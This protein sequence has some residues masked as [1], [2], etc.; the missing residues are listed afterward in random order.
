MN[1]YNILA[2]Y[3]AQKYIDR[4]SGNDL[5]DRIVGDDPKDQIMTGLLAE[6]R[7]EK[8]FSGFYKEN[9]DTKYESVPSIGLRF[10][11]DK[12]D[13]LEISIVP[14]GILFYS[15]LPNYEEVVEYF[16]R[17]ESSK[18]NKKYTNI[19]QLI[20]IYPDKQLTLPLVYK[21][22]RLENIFADGIKINIS[23]QDSESIHLEEDIF[24]ELSS[25]IQKIYKEIRVVNLE[26]FTYEELKHP[27]L[28]K[29]VCTCRE[30]LVYPSW[31]L[32]ILVSTKFLEDKCNIFVQMV[33]KSEKP[34]SRN[35]GFLPQIY[36]AGLDII[37]NAN[38]VFNEIKLDYFSD[39]Y[40]NREKCYAI[41]DNTSSEY[42]QNN[43]TISTLNIP[44]YYQYR[45]KTN[46]NYNSYITFQ[47]LIDNPVDNLQYI[48]NQLK[49]DL[50]NRK[51]EF[52]SV[53]N[54]LSEIAKDKFQRDL[55]NYE[56][57]IDRF[58]FGIEQIKYK[59]I[60]KK[61]F[62]LMN[63]S[64]STKVPGD[65]KNYIGWRLFQIVFI[66]SLI[67]E[68]IA[69]EYKDD[70]S[71]K[72]ATKVETANLL[73]FPTGGGKTE[74]FL[75]ISVFTMFF[76]RLRGKN[77][78]VTGI[79]KYPLRL[80]AVQQLDRVLS[81]IM[82]AN[83]IRMEDNELKNTTEFSL[84]FLIGSSN[85]PNK[86]QEND[87]YNNGSYAIV[88]G[89]TETLNEG[90]RF[91]DKCPVCGKKSISVYFDQEDWR[92][93]HICTNEDCNVDTLPL[94]IIDNEIYRYLPTLIVSTVDKMA[95]LGFSEDFKQL[96]GQVRYKCKKH[97]YS[98][99]DN[100]LAKYNCEEPLSTIDNIVDPIPTL[101]IQDELH[102]VRESLGTFDAHYESFIKY[103]AQNLVPLNQQKQIR[104]IGATATI[105]MYEDH[106]SHLYHMRGRRF[107]CEYPSC[108]TEE[109]FYSYIDKTDI[110]RI[111]MGF[112][113]YGRSISKGMWEAVYN[114]RFIVS[115]IK[116]DPFNHFQ[117]LKEKGFSGN[118]DD[119]ENMIYDYWI[120]LIYN[121]R[122]DDV[123]N[124]ANAF[125]NQ[126]NDRLSDLG[127]EKFVTTQMTSDTNFQEVRK[128]LF[129]IQTNKTKPDSV[130]AILATSTISHGVD[131]DSFNNMFFYGMPNTNAEYIQ[132]YSRSGRKYTGLVIDII[133]LL[134]VRDRA[135]L[136][137]F[138]LFHENKDDLVESVP[139]NR[140]AKN[141]IYNTLPG[142]LCG[143]IIQYYTRVLGINSL[144]KVNVF[145][146]YLVDGSIDIADITQKV[147]EIYGCTEHEKLSANYKKIIEREVFNIVSAIRNKIYDADV[148]ITDAI[149]S[150]YSKKFRPMTSL[151][152][153][154]ENIEVS[155]MEN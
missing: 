151:R 9:E 21:K 108:K 25:A 14:R 48:Y 71:I 31:K 72:G 147:I 24:R 76:D 12:T 36:N 89:T 11:I 38:T 96:L 102:L 65:S 66:V 77:I 16:L 22:I 34:N 113:P 153:T 79:L 52:D 2:N 122:K 46:D 91:I 35:A 19:E 4:I 7:V 123:I 26:P 131:E 39:S 58:Y 119:L 80:L 92:L 83:I 139:I 53:K 155:L 23:Q 138:K 15:V 17:S 95:A 6:N 62:I 51:K 33:N 32:D 99:K 115:Q 103:Y 49:H 81:V 20:E 59:D 10:T 104:Y 90:Y 56:N 86:I 130:N 132:A 70:Q 47:K 42:N 146:K 127:M 152:D 128:N 154:E 27:E 134:R 93:K 137:N 106:L 61:A 110:T 140:W 43:N 28:F 117:K 30:E 82:K 5:P 143:L 135:Y 98:W 84:G 121:N 94:Y 133:R 97:G 118:L 67:C 18:D 40:K 148:Y 88:H 126:A 78:G 112:A 45:T 114:M 54:R 129:D 109:N 29:L 69:S 44:L 142:I 105:S 75:G 64:F 120:C 100:C 55:E 13:N 101:F 141:A 107:P 150:E 111:I 144:Y 63:K 73:Y 37:G 74:A 85:T 8:S 116:N 50:D 60:V 3:I 41:G 68:I 136:K 87:R 57:E 124:L 1:D 145:K 149:K 125:E